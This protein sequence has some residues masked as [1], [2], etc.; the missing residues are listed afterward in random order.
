MDIFLQHWLP[1]NFLLDA[2]VFFTLLVTWYL[3]IL[4]NSFDIGSIKFVG[5]SL[6]LSDLF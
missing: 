2:I 5:D 6:A 3:C 4:V 1:G